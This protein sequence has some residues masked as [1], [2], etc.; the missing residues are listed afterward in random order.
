MWAYAPG[1]GSLVDIGR[2]WLT[3]W[4]K[5]FAMTASGLT[6]ISMRKQDD[7][8]GASLQGPQRLTFNAMRAR[9][10]DCTTSPSELIVA[11]DANV[12][13]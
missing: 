9:E 5:S 13:V 11:D 1:F 12:S 4:A 6:C 2:Q 10:L 8:C 3:A 7:A